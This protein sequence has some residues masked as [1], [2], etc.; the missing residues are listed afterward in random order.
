MTYQEAK[1]LVDDFSFVYKGKSI[2]K[3]MLIECREVIHKALEKQIPKKLKD[4]EVSRFGLALLCPSC[5]N[6]VAMIW[7]S[8]L[9]KGKY[10]QSYCDNCGQALDW[11]DVK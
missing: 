9:E 5:E 3:E 4:K 6:Q 1:A 8:V 2:S 10:K 7:E 11:E